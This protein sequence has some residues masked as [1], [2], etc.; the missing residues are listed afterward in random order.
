MTGRRPFAELV[1]DWPPE[2]R[3][4]VEARAAEML[5]EI[6]AAEAAERAALPPERGHAKSRPQETARSA[7]R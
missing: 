2:R 4:R 6:E 5:A 3:R 1:K 7:E